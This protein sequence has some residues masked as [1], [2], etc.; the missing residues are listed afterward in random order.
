MFKEK[1]GPEREAIAPVNKRVAAVASFYDPHAY[2]Y[3]EP[4]SKETFTYG[5]SLSRNLGM[6]RVAIHHEFLAPGKQSS[7]AHAHSY[8]EEAVYV[9]KGTP[10]LYIKGFPQ[11]VHPGEFLFFKPGTGLTHCLKN[12]T[13]EHC[14]FLVVGEME[15]DDKDQIIYE[16]EDR[17]DMCKILGSFWEEAPVVEEFNFYDI[18]CK[19]NEIEWEDFAG[20]EEEHKI[21]GRLK[22]FARAMGA[23]R[24]AFKLIELPAGM[25]TSYPHAELLEEEFGYILNGRPTLWF[26]DRE[27]ELS[28]E[29][30]I[31]FPSGEG[32]VH[33][34]ENKTDAKVELIFSGELSKIGNKYFYPQHPDLKKISDNSKYWWENPPEPASE[35][36]K[37]FD[38]K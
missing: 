24:I 34:F 32:L 30:V 35:L 14:E 28:S 13:N 5:A 25:K 7:W 1:V 10:T 9:L 16:N 3:Y 33:T 2:A 20:Y 22:D 19:P 21:G 11:V 27:I 26:H 17:N 8:E 15:T 29:M 18:V 36:F 12:E 37:P 4:L 31:G 38:E 6:K 23:R